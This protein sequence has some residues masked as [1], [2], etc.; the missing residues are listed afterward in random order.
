MPQV[1]LALKDVLAGGTFIALGVAFAAGALTYDIGTA[2]RMG[3]GYVPLVLGVVLA[4]LGVLVIV[5]GFVAGEGDP[6]GEV[7]WRAVILITAALLFFGITV[8][9][10]GV[11]GALFG[12]SLLAALARSQTSVREALVIAVGLTALSVVIFIVALQLRLPL[13]GSW[14]PL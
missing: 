10:L 13:V 1:R 2:V 5:K 4:G 9:G 11:V 3:P 6:I 8:R 7:E 12:A 14:I